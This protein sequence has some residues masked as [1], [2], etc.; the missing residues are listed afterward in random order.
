MGLPSPHGGELVEQ[1]GPPPELKGLPRHE[2]SPRELA[3]LECLATGVYSPLRGFMG[4]EDYRRVLREM[5]LASGLLFSLPITL[6]LKEEEAA[7]LGPKEALVLTWH[8]E[9]LGLLEVEELFR[10]DREEEARAVYGTT[11]LKHPGVATLFSSGP[12]YV[13]GT[14]RLFHPVPHS[15]FARYRLT[16]RET[17]RIFAERGW[18]SVAAFQTRNPLHRAHEYLHKVALE[19][20]DGLLLH[21]LVGETKADD[22]PATLRVRSY[23]VALEHYYPQDRVLLAVFPGAMRY[24]GPREALLH[25][26]ARKNYGASHFIVGRDH[27]GVGGYYPP[28]AAHRIFDALEEELGIVP[29]RFE[30]AHYCRRCQG[31]VTSKTC[32]HG[33][34]SW[35]RL[36]GTQVRQML[37][38]GIPLPPEFTRPE[39]AELL[40]RAYQEEHA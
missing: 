6:A 25:A 16:P 14:A 19:L 24:A 13:G 9:P 4:A 33:E 8:Q 32:P 23:E 38:Q 40:L 3:D 36:S 31:M 35:V 18:R 12:V 29:L 39:V 37:R 34:A 26:I 20:T 11:D 2:L 7:Q 30:E 27:A 5:R 15:H 21:P 22:L 10:P 28:Y 17:R 1:L